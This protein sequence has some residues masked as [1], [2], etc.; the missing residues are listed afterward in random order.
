MIVSKF[1]APK[2]VMTIVHFNRI[3]MQRQ[4]PQVWSVHNRF[5]CFQ[6]RK[7][8]MHVPMESVFDPNGRQP[9]AKFK[10]LALLEVKNEEAHLY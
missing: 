3:A 2:K 10:G 6:V 5:G 7:V 1:S 8:F 4:E 9:R